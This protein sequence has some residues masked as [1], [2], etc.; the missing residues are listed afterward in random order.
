MTSRDKFERDYTILYEKYNYAT[1]TWGPL[2]AGL[3]SGKYNS[4]EIPKDTRYG[5]DPVA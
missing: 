3:L 1:C 5:A 2:A 4:G